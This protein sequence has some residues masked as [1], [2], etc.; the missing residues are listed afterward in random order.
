MPNDFPT[1]HVAP[2]TPELG[3]LSIHEHYISGDQSA[4]CPWP[5]CTNEPAQRVLA[6]ASAPESLDYWLC[7]DCG[8]TSATENPPC[9]SCG[10]HRVVWAKAMSDM[11]DDAGEA[12]GPLRARLGLAE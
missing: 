2:L 1:I 11:L 9:S 4:A 6:P 12:P 5:G 8:V 10:G 3:A 7:A